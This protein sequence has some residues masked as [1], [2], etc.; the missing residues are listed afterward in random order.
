MK[1]F[2]LLVCL[3]AG[4]NFNLIAQNHNNIK[5]TPKEDTVCVG[6][7][8]QLN[9][10]GNSFNPVSYL[11][12][13]GQTTPTIN[14]N[15]SG[16]YGVTVTGYVGQSNQMI[17][18]FKTKNFTVLDKPKINPLSQTW[19]CKFDT[20]TLEVDLGY[21]N[22]V[23]NNGSSNT[24]FK[25]QMVGSGAGATLDTVS[26][27]YTAFINNVCQ[28]NSDTIVIRGIRRPEGVG[29]FFNGRTNLN[30]NDSVPAGLVLT[31]LYSPQYEMEF[32]KVSDPNYVV[33]WITP[34]TTRKAPLNILDAGFNYYVRTRP[35]INGITYCWG[36]YSL[37]GILPNTSNRIIVENFIN[38]LNQFE[39]YD[40]GGRLLVEKRGY[41]FDNNWLND[42]PN[43]NIIV[44]QKNKYGIQVIRKN[45]IR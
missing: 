4:I 31:Y 3:I 43:Q 23:W 21:N 30:S 40:L 13:N 12:S 20:V 28:I 24:I 32:T 39:F 26:V 19:V 29:S 2:I 22:Y 37:I 9:I 14:I 11:W 27:W 16:V 17:T 15:S 10:A 1:K 8:A 44:V 7:S 33:T 38:E 36:N 34:N 18:I 35:I 45:S 6:T 42:F 41:N 5:I 25:R